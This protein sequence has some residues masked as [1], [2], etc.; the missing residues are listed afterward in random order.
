[1]LKKWRKINKGTPI[2]P[3]KVLKP[4]GDKIDEERT[5][6]ASQRKKMTQGAESES[7]SEDSGGESDQSD[8]KD[9]K[10]SKNKKTSV[11]KV[12][13]SELKDE[14]QL[15]NNKTYVVNSGVPSEVKDKKQSKNSGPSL[16]NSG[17]LP[18][19]KEQKQSKND[20]TSEVNNVIPEVKV[21]DP[22]FVS[23][24][25]TLPKLLLSEVL[26][27]PKKELK[28]SRDEPEPNRW[29]RG[30]QFDKFERVPR[31][32]STR[33]LPHKQDEMEPEK[34]VEEEKL[35]PSWAAKKVK[36]IQPFQGKKIKF[37]LD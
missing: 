10:Q 15:K 23:K 1:M 27:D 34:P 3:R 9:E 20:R 14:K 36:L 16:V 24:K 19:I 30:N 35:H 7:C 28:F 13:P 29:S 8:V 37:D 12:V 31:E 5:D 32:R 6:L 2:K 25:I 33:R 18:E 26:E 4:P 22:F 11:L 17:V 21:D